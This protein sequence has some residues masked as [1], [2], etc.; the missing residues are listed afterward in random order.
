[1]NMKRFLRNKVS[2]VGLV[3][4]TIVIC[5]GLFSPW[6]APHDPLKHNMA[7]R[8]ADPSWQ[9]VG[10]T[11]RYGR[12]VFSRTIWGA[13]VSLLVGFSAVILGVGAGTILGMI[14][15]FKKGRIGSGIMW[16]TDVFLSFPSLVLAIIVV[17]AFGA[18]TR[19]VVFSIGL[20]FVPRCIRLSRAS[21]LAVSEQMYVEASK[22]VGQSDLKII[23]KHILPNISGEVI[24]MSTLWIAT[25]I[26][27]EAS[28]SFL[29]LGTQPPTP[30]WGMMV[31]AGTEHFI[32]SPLLCLV[33]GMGIFM[34][35]MGFN[36]IG[37]ALRD[38]L[39]PKLRGQLG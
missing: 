31:R 33:P 32:Q 18:N 34:A 5:M 28:L 35:T 13:R 2:C 9:H 16:L 12:D 14:A 7:N 24:V 17:V 15:G 39:D 37:D 22:A 10:G 1:M 21:T 26:R 29:G 6:L 23:W 20:A 38:N 3:F 36:M 8:F 11:D 19:T 4:V 30:S 27:L 25:A